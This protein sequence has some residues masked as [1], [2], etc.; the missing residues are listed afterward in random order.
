MTQKQDGS[1]F[2]YFYYPGPDTVFL[3][4]EVFFKVSAVWW[5][6]ALYRFPLSILSRDVESVKEVNCSFLVS[7][8][9]SFI[10]S[11]EQKRI[12]IDAS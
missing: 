1:L 5:K 11:I 9:K 12:Q 4:V 3:I 2:Y 8:H 6:S 7:L 10:V